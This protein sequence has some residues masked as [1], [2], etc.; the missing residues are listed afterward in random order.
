MKIFRRYAAQTLRKNKTRTLVTIIGIILS[1]SMITAV[2]TMFSSLQEYLYQRTVSVTG[3]WHGAAFGLSGKAWDEKKAD[4]QLDSYVTL[5][6]L[7]YALLEGCQ[8]QDKPFCIWAVWMRSS[9]NIC[10]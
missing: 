10:R 2:T 3:D 6:N 8:N 7:G 1:A 4:R 5:E 9:R